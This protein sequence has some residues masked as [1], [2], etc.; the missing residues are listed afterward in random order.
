MNGYEKFFKEARKSSAQNS[1][2]T[3]KPTQGKIASSGN[4]P[5]LGKN[6]TGER[7]SGARFSVKQDKNVQRDQSNLTPEKR[8]TLELSRKMKQRKIQARKPK[9]KFPLIP[10]LIGCLTI[11]VLALNVMEPQH[12][13]LQKAQSVFNKVEFRLMGEASAETSNSIP[14]S[15]SKKNVGKEK[16]SQE[17]LSSPLG[18]S[19][20]KNAGSPGESNLEKLSDVKSWSEEELSF[21]KKLS[22]RKKE[23]DLR[24]ADLNRLED[25]LQKQK[26]EL[27]LR[28]K[29][30]EEM[31]GMISDTL[32][33]RVA[34]DQKKV[35]KLVEFYSTMKPSQAAKV[36]ESLNDDLAVEVLDKMKKKNAAEI[37]NMMDA[38]KALHLSEL[39]TG[40]RRSNAQGGLGQKASSEV[41]APASESIGPSAQE[42]SSEDMSAGEEK[43]N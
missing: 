33:S 34:E 3:K 9:V 40:Y 19:E 2:E 37:M 29:K 1:S 35:D 16:D 41:R 39:M 18:S 23:L 14:N 12:P 43:K 6:A 25:E 13:F 4:K 7:K 21:F 11:G 20:E 28:L 26:S 31:R 27:D 42:S 36:M 38:K 17:N 30:L 10:A 5:A 15:A 24:E 8:L 22:E 32:K